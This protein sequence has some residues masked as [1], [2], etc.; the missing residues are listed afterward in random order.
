MALLTQDFKHVDRC[1]VYQHGDK[2]DDDLIYKWILESNFPRKKPGEGPINEIV[3]RSE[4]R[5]LMEDSL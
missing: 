1:Q 4:V 5:R 2:H 3:T